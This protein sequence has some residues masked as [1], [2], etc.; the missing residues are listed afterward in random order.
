MTRGSTSVVFSRSTT[1]TGA[2]S[3]RLRTMST[4][5]SSGSGAPTIPRSVR[6]PFTAGERIMMITKSLVDFDL[7]TY[8]VPIEDLERNS[9]WVSHIQSMSPDFDV[10]YSNNPLVIQLFRG[11]RH[12]NP[13]V[14]NVQPRRARGIRVRER[15]ITA[16][17][18][19]RSSPKPSSRSSARWTASSGSRWSATRTRTATDFSRRFVATIMITL[20]SDFARRTRGDERSDTTANG[21]QTGR[22]GPRF[23]RQDVRTAAFWLQEVLPYFPPATH[24]VVVDPGVGT[25]R[26][27]LVVRAGDHALVGPDNGVLLPAA[28]GLARRR[29]RT[30]DR[31][32][33][34]AGDRPRRTDDAGGLDGRLERTGVDDPE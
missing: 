1:A 2:W 22:R 29:G 6:N 25:D 34:R 13:P 14:A 12:R 30:R 18:G 26:N 5:S 7:V 31:A 33:R 23:P 32:D 28:R 16:A 9:V 4:S 11:G 21:R 3:R 19:S 8:A 17:T 27:A 24:L 15:M 20:S 10:A